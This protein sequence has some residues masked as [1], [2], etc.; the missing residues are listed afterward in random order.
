MRIDTLFVAGVGQVL[1][2]AG[3]AGFPCLLVSDKGA[4]YSTFLT[5]HNVRENYGR[6]LTLA[7]P[8]ERHTNVRVSDI[9]FGQLDDYDISDAIRENFSFS[10][11]FE[12][13][14]N[15]INPLNALS[16][17]SPFTP[18]A[19]ASASCQPL[20]RIIRIRRKHVN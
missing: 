2:E 10:K 9:E 6:N 12:E 17:V 13:Y 14:L 16:S 4:E 3:A 15:Y 19:M 5:R 7:H 11:R 1:L 20:F 18:S 8:A